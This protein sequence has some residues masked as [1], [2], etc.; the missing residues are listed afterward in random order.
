MDLQTLNAA[1]LEGWFV[2]GAIICCNK[3]EV[4][5]YTIYTIISNF[6]IKCHF[7]NYNSKHKIKGEPTI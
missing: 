5:C 6:V 2:V 1:T 3:G 7:F 4:K